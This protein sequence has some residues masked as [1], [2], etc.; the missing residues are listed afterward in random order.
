MAERG[1][2]V[3]GG[4][5]VREGLGAVVARLFAAE[6]YGAVLAGRT[7]GHLET[8]AAAIRAAGG[9]AI[10]CPTDATD[11]SAVGALF[12]AAVSAYGHV[13]AAVFNVGGMARGGV[14][15]VIP[16]A[17]EAAWRHGAYA[18]FVFCREAAKR[19]LPRGEG[20]ILVTG[21]TASVK[22]SAGFLPFASA[23]F[24][25]RGLSQ[26]LARELGP[27]GIHVAHFIID[28]VIE[29]D[30]TKEWFGDRLAKMPKDSLMDAEAI[31]R[32]YLDAHRQH[33]SAWAFEVDLRPWVE[34]F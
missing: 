1:A 6:G 3:V 18:G 9:R 24:A 21:A 22:G 20:S 29:S 31:A 33:R 17:F 30:R 10:A 32:V 12:D 13:A 25:L 15:E 26:S 19:M 28:G 11:E 14:L 34:K 16:D 4:V 27:K 8:A 2:V 5:G 7:P 23:K